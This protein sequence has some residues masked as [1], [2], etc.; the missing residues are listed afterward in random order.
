MAMSMMPAGTTM[1]QW[2]CAQAMLKVQDVVIG[3]VVSEPLNRLS[4]LMVDILSCIIDRCGLINVTLSCMI[5]ENADGQTASSIDSLIMNY[6]VH[7]CYSTSRMMGHGRIIPTGWIMSRQGFGRVSTQQQDATGAASA[8]ATGGGIRMAFIGYV[9]NSIIIRMKRLLDY[10][11]STSRDV[12]SVVRVISLMGLYDTHSKIDTRTIPT[13]TI[14]TQQRFID[15]MVAEFNH[16]R[17]R[18]S[19][20]G[21]SYINCLLCGP[22][23]SGKTIV[24]AQLTKALNGRLLV[25]DKIDSETKKSLQRTKHILDSETKASSRSDASD[26]SVTESKATPLVI[27][28]DEFDSVIAESIPK[29]PDECIAKMKADGLEG[30]EFEQAMEEMQ[31]QLANSTTT[32]TKVTIN[33]FMDY[34]T[35]MDNCI[36]IF[37]SNTTMSRV[38]ASFTRDGRITHR[39]EMPIITTDDVL[40]LVKS[41]AIKFGWDHKQLMD[42]VSSSVTMHLSQLE[43]ES[44]SKDDVGHVGAFPLSVATMVQIL[45]LSKS[46]DDA[47]TM[48]DDALLAEREKVHKAKARA[49]FKLLHDMSSYVSCDDKKKLEAAARSKQSLSALA[50]SLGGMLRSG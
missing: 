18:P 50:A 34:L 25:I 49:A 42:R 26:A 9:R 17:S 31:E 44:E 4:K 32:S 47:V 43:S 38:N 11:K 14:R 45:D 28:I 27:L 30:K 22:Q 40:E 3:S 5:D 24:A 7:G 19:L 37:I 35:T 48:L 8:S 13:Y 39:M 20:R 23:G 1:K 10:L 16:I 29:V 41:A 36:T 46:I 33:A 15:T 12:P 2:L 6:I 21:A